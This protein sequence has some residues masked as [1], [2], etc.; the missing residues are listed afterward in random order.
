MQGFSETLAFATETM[1][2]FV[3]PWLELVVGRSPGT[4]RPVE[5]KTEDNTA[6]VGESSV[7]EASPDGHSEVRS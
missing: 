2:G 5:A 4:S 6:F 7:S 1:V 3:L